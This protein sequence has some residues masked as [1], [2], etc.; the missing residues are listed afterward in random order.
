M[1]GLNL[2]YCT[3]KSNA[4]FFWCNTSIKMYF[5]V[6]RF[7]YS[8]AFCIEVSSHVAKFR[9]SYLVPLER[10]CQLVD[11]RSVLLL[12]QERFVFIAPLALNL[13]KYTK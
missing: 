5:Y 6:M 11:V 13:P 2:R 4:N 10:P 3:I 9:S 7:T 8:A 12:L 1:N